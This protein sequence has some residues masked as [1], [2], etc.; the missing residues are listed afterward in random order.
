M[1]STKIERMSV[2]M[3][4]HMDRKI[5]GTQKEVDFQRRA[6][7]L[8]EHIINDRFSG[9][10]FHVGSRGE[11][12][13]LLASDTDMM[14]TLPMVTMMYPDQCTCIPPNIARNTILYIREADCR[15]G[16][17]HLQLGQLG[18]K[19]LNL[20]KDSFI[21]T[22][23]S[24]FVSSDIFRE[25]WVSESGNLSRFSWESNG[26]SST[27]LGQIDAV[28]CF[29]CNCW[30]REA[31]EW[32]TRTR[33]YGWPHQT[34]IDQIVHSGCQLVPVGDKCSV[35]TL[36]QWRF[37]FATSEISLV[38]S[39]SHI[40]FK[41]YAL[42]K[43]FLKQIKVTLRET[44]GDDDIL[45]SYFL[46]TILFHAIENSSQ[47]FWQE[48]HLI[49]CFRFCLN[50]L[51]AWVKAGVCPNYFIPANNLFQRKVHGQNQEILL[52]ILNNYWQMKWPC[53]LVGNL[54][55]FK[56]YPSIWEV[57]S[58][59]TDQ[60]IIFRQDLK[61]CRAIREIAFC[62]IIGTLWAI[63]NAINSLSK[64]QSDS[65]EVFA[66]QYTMFCLQRLLAAEQASQD[67][68]AMD[69]KTR[70]KGLRKCKNWMIHGASMGT[71]LLRLATFH[72]L[73]GNFIK[74]L[75]V[76]E[77]VMKLAIYFTSFRK[78]Q[79]KIEDMFRFEYHRSG[80]TLSRLRKIYTY[81]ITF[82]RRDLY[83][84]HLWLEL[85][86]NDAE[87]HIPPL[88]YAVFLSFLCCH[89]LGDTRGRDTSLRNMEEVQYEE[90]QGGHIY[91]IVHTL[92]GICYEIL[93]DSRRAIR[94][95]W[96]SAQSTTIFLTVSKNPAIQRIA[97][98][99]L[100]MYASKKDNRG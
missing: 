26:P 19:C 46:K 42:L 9:S 1:D 74:S 83:L 76:C 17:V 61:T 30:P 23:D 64:T 66:Y 24:T 93:G 96:N 36:L 14:V 45:C 60:E 84:P 81:Y 20:L 99:Y 69:N 73:T 5:T 82:T 87:L 47:L 27:M 8:K 44:I 4:T 75:K 97:S 62:P 7:V 25:S 37:S 68:Y 48:K 77:Q 51:I 35:D 67:H 6:C 50:I 88:P 18:Q 80:H 55:L 34:L 72:F 15:P 13:D 16:Y 57:E 58:P 43:C 28:Y 98:V 92:L 79:E 53:L 38:H 71:E 70:Y 40:Q 3:S 10:V 11:G 12:F 2:V 89:E 91:W 100:C 29:P 78:D 41:V 86:N 31:N 52:D 22:G 63:R 39:F 49:Y 32:I 85:T 21:R 95:Y 90:R 56:F 33:L 59:Q 94:A 54:I 65:D